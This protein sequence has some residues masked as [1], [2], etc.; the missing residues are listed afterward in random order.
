MHLT[1]GQCRRS[2]FANRVCF[3]GEQRRG[4]TVQEVTLKQVTLKTA[5]LKTAT[6]KQ[7]TWQQLTLQK[8]DF[9]CR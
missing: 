8:I 7:A 3:L 6:L 2:V 9:G 4:I 5:T 1:E